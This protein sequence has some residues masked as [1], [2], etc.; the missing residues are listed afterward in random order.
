M[1][2]KSKHVHVS[3]NP[4][5]LSRLD[6]LRGDT[7]MGTYLLATFV[8]FSREVEAGKADPRRVLA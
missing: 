5:M 2:A 1:G 8:R 4:E 6:E 7:P 3:L